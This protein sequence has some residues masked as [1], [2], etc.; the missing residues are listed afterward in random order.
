M[1]RRRFWQTKP[2]PI[3]IEVAGTDI[4][5]RRRSVIVLDRADE[6]CLRIAQK[7]AN[8]TG[9]TVTVRNPDMSEIR[10]IPAPRRVPTPCR[11]VD[12]TAAGP[13]PASVVR[14][15]NL[16][17]Q[18]KAFLPISRQWGC[19]KARAASRFRF[20]GPARW[21]GR[22]PRQNEIEQMKALGQRQAAR[23]ACPS[24]PRSLP[25]SSLVSP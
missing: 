12:W 8:T 10:T 20:F 6:K 24:A 1:P 19:H 2:Q 21:R 3:I 22:S 15:N 11:C 16:G 13:M 18:R 25:V 14:S 5:L 17:D 9:R 23:P 4:Q 7:I